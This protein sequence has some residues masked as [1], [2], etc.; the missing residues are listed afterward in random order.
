MQQTIEDF[1]W[2]H[3]KGGRYRII[4]LAVREADLM[5]MVVYRSNITGATFVRPA[6]EFFDGR[7]KDTR[8]PLKR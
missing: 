4:T 8:Q 1:D 7:F 5:P 2:E 3:V 6:A